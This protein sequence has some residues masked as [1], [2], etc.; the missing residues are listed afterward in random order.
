MGLFAFASTR[1]FRSC[2]RLLPGTAPASGAR[3]KEPVSGLGKMRAVGR[4]GGSARCG[5]AASSC[6]SRLSVRA[7]SASLKPQHPR[8]PQPFR[9]LHQASL[10]A[11]PKRTIYVLQKRT[12]HVLRTGDLGHDVRCPPVGLH[13]PL[14]GR[15]QVLLGIRSEPASVTATAAV[16][17][18]VLV[19]R[20]PPR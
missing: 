14:V 16:V 20:K 6:V 8:L 1:S 13:V 5:A 9:G 19:A 17:R 7:S 18:Y 11:H 4:S 15:P 2:R 10:P 3:V 12:D